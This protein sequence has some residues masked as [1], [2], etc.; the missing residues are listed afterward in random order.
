[1]KYIIYLLLLVGFLYSCEDFLTHDDPGSVTTDDKWWETEANATGAVNNLYAGVPDG[2]NGRNAM[3]VSCMTDEAIGRQSTVGDYESFTKSLQNSDWGV[4]LHIWRDNYKNIRRAN[5]FIEN[6][7]KALMSQTLKERYINEARA[8]R[9]YYHMELFM[10]FGPIPISKYSLDPNENTLVRDSEEDCYDFIISELL[11]AAEG[12]PDSYSDNDSW[13]ISRPTCWAFATR[14]AM[15]KNN[16]EQGREY[17]K[18]IINLKKSGKSLFALYDGGYDKLFTYEAE[19]SHNKE[20]LFYKREGASYAWNRFAPYSIAGRVTASPTASV[21]DNFETKQGKTIWEVDRDS[22]KIYKMNPNVKNNRDPRLTAS[23][24]LP[25]ETFAD[26]VIDPFNEDPLN[27]NRIGV[28][29]STASGYWVKKYLDPLDQFRSQG[30]RKLRYM[31]VRY[32]EVLLNY[33]ECK[34]ELNQFNDPEVIEYLNEIRNRAGMPNVNVN[35]YNTQE[36]LRELVR[37]ERQAELCFEGQRFFD[38]RRWNIADKLMNGTVYGATN[39]K[40]GETYIVEE[41]TYRPERDARYP[42]PRE[43]IVANKNMVQN[44]GY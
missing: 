13:R 34:I 4:A 2:M 41:R 18:K 5:R 20:V 31:I 26:Q 21:V 28:Q 38:I 11:E 39:P 27:T 6:V 44:P 3:L 15:F 22:L 42:I 36:K 43:E 14:L 23:V 16:Y 35:I 25:G 24:I 30:N 17:S 19:G 10:F 7:G 12:L 9:A 37:R 40:T 32:A 33:V 1:M 8:L 29:G